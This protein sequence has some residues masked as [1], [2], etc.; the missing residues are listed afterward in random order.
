VVLLGTK[1][2]HDLFMASRLT[3]DV[4]RQL[5]SRVMMHYPLDALNAAELKAIVQRALGDEAD[6]EMVAD[7]LSETGGL[8]R[9]VEFILPQII[10]LMKRN[11]EQLK[12]GDRK[13]LRKRIVMVAA[14]KLM[15]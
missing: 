5:S 6:D 14:S 3:E 2:L 10:D 7:I 11:H 12:G 13:S 4:R 9:H 8:F 1:D 15:K